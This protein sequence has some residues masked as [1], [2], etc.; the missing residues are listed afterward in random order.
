MEDAPWKLTYDHGRQTWEPKDYDKEYLG[1]IS[2]RTSRAHSI[3]TVTAHL[4][5]DI[6]I[7]HVIETAHKLGE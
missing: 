3:N 1:W 5:F 4:A 2:L 6:G 7:D